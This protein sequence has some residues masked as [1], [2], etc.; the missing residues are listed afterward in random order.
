MGNVLNTPAVQQAAGA[1]AQKAVVNLLQGSPL[2][3][4]LL[5]SV[6]GQVAKGTVESLLGKPAAQNLIGSLAVDIANG[7][8]ASELTNA[9]IHAVITSPGLQIAVGM[10]VGQGIGSL[11]G[12]NLIGAAVGGVLGVTATLFVGVASGFALL[13]SGLSSLFGLGGAAAA[14]SSAASGY[15]LAEV[16]AGSTLLAMSGV[17]N[18][19]DG[20]ALRHAAPV[21]AWA[22]LPVGGA[23]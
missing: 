18:P 10:A 7:M 1:A 22:W 6:A 23:V 11:L 20:A 12:D 5:E 3:N 21:A 13:V 2:N 15:T 19:Q 9:V 4:K 17:R 14:A 8:P 16:V